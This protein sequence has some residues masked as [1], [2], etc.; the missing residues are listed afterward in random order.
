MEREKTKSIMAVYIQ[1]GACPQ[2]RQCKFPQHKRQTPG[3]QVQKD[4]QD[5]TVTAYDDQARI[6]QS[7]TKA[8]C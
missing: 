4:Y 6:Q 8:E 5:F 3:V 7:C 1:I 2:C